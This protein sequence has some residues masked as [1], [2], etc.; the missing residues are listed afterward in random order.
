METGNSISYD[1]VETELIDNCSEETSEMRMDSRSTD[2]LDCITLMI[3]NLSE[4]KK[5][6]IKVL[7][8]TWESL[9]T[10]G[11]QEGLYVPNLHLEFFQ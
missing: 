6:Q 11:D 4:E 2:K 3:D 8:I 7:D 1:Y 10:P 9:N 5:D